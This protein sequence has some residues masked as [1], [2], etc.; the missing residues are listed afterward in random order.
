MFFSLMEADKEC[1]N[2][3][4]AHLPSR[5]PGGLQVVSR[6]FAVICVMADFNRY[7]AGRLTGW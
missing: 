6:D 7:D 2:K 1:G 5:V 4:E 3:C